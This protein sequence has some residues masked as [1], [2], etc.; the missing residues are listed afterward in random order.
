MLVSVLG[1]LFPAVTVVLARTFLR[2]RIGPLQAVGIVLALVAV[3]L[4]VAG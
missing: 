3:A 2:E 4:I 1:S